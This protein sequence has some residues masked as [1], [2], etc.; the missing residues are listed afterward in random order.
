MELYVYR[1]ASLTH[2]AQYVSNS[3]LL[4]DRYVP[5]PYPV[6]ASV[7]KRATPTPETRRT[8]GHKSHMPAP[9]LLWQ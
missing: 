8:V 5:Q 1:I 2:W 4:F 6:I 3:P 9:G 7:T